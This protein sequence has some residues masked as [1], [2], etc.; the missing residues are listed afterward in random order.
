MLHR[1]KKQNDMSHDKWIA[2]GGH[3]EEGETPL[4]CAKREVL[5][6]TG[7]VVESLKYRAKLLFINDDYSEIM[8][9][10]VADSFKGELIECDEGDLEWVKKEDML[11]LNIWEGDKEFLKLM[12]K[13]DNY[14]EMSLFYSNDKFIKSIDRID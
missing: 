1:T 13:D 11:S 8:H 9:L 7:L 14:F 6:E 2:V 3:L 5:E 4:E 12:L 10:F